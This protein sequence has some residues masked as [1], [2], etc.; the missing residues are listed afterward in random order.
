MEYISH[1]S[2][3]PLT[4]LRCDTQMER[5]G[6]VELLTQTVPTV[7]IPNVCCGGWGSRGE[8]DYRCV[9]WAPPTEWPDTRNNGRGLEIFL[10]DNSQTG[11]V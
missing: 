4:V 8:R 3:V 5:L 1:P 2:V 7:N 10:L 6:F 11:G 9:W